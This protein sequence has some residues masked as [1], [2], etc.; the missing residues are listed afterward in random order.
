LNKALASKYIFFAG[1]CF[2]LLVVV[3]FLLDQQ[4]SRTLDL[5]G[6]NSSG[7][8]SVWFLRDQYAF[9]EKNLPARVFIGD[10]HVFDLFVWM[11]LL[12]AVMR[13]ISGLFALEQFEAVSLKLSTVKF[14]SFRY[15]LSVLAFGTLAIVFPM[16][17]QMSSRVYQIAYLM[18]HSVRAFLCLEAVVFCGGVFFFAE[19]L[20]F[21]LWLLLK[22][23]R[24]E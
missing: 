16:R 24:A 15:L 20:M 5:I 23:K 14:S 2:W 1:A 12:L 9:F 8:S 3:G 10:I 11:A 21:A 18:Q 13:V 22:S 7:V 4:L 6:Y 17:I 19:G